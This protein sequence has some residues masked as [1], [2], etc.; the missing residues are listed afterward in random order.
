MVQLL[1]DGSLHDLQL[2]SQAPH[3][4]LYVPL[5]LSQKVYVPAGHAARH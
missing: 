1:G 5:L 2:E 3:E 4:P